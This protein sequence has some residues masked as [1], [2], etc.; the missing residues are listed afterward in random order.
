[1]S[2]IE[3]FRQLQ[4]QGAAFSDYE[5]EKADLAASLWVWRSPL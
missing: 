1:M 3:I 2:E 4:M 5:R